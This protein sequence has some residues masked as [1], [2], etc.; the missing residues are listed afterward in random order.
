VVGTPGPSGQCDDSY[1]RVVGTPGPSGQYDD[2]QF[3]HLL[4]NLERWRGDSIPD[5]VG[6]IK[7]KRAVTLQLMSE[8]LVW[9]SLPPKTKLS[10]GSTVVVEP[11]TSRCVNRHILVVR[12]VTPLWGDGWLPV[13]IVNPITSPVTLR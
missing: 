13:K 4:S 7:L 6:T 1:W 9:G 3:L 2:S 11:S 12:V 10:V 5:K 8:H